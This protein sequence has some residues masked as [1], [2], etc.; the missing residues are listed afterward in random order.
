MATKTKRGA[1]VILTLHQTCGDVQCE[2]CGFPIFT[3]DTFYHDPRTEA[4]T[5]S[6]QCAATIRLR[7]DLRPF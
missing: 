3:G 4:V 2:E 1:L 5:C 7:G 6:E